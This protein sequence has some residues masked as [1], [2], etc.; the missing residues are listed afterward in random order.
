[1]KATK[2]QIVSGLTV[3]LK[4]EILPKMDG[5]KALQIVATVAINAAAANKKLIDA[6]FSNDFVKAAVCDDGN[7]LYDLN[8][9]AEALKAAMDQFGNLPVHL[10]PIPLISPG[11]VVLTLSAADVDAIMRRIENAV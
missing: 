10:P 8:G 7:G 11:E 9:V 4:D 1:M 2:S 6:V 5:Q 3:Y